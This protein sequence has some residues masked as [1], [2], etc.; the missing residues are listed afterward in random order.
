MRKTF[1]DGALHR[2]LVSRGLVKV[3]I[4]GQAEVISLRAA[5]EALQPADRFCPADGTA[6]NARSYHCTFLDTDLAYKRAFDELVRATFDPIVDR[7]LDHHRLLIANCYVKP[8]GRGEFEVHQNWTLAPSPGDITM[9]I[10]V[11]L[12]ATTSRNGTLQVVPRSHR[13]TRDV[14]YPR[15]DYFFSGFQDRIV[16]HHYESV[17]VAAG[18]AVFFD[19]SLI[20][21]SGTNESDEPRFALQL[22]VLPAEL[23]PVVHLLRDDGDFDQLDGGPALYLESTQH[24]IDRWPERFRRLGTVANRNRRLT[25]AEFLGLLDRGDDVR[26]DLWGIDAA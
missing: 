26:H 8:P 24:E 9:T 22:A 12:Q 13:L 17:E 18:E 15:G 6:T 16:Q 4:L 23:P 2:S 11:P 1:V 10:W 20:H 14:A 5:I 21:G 3:P 7:L 19:D 25:E